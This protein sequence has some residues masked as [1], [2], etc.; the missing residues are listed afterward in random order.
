M[1]FVKYYFIKD[2][3]GLCLHHYGKDVTMEIRVAAEK[4]QWTVAVGSM[5]DVITVQIYAF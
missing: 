3:L 1:C 5:L 4:Q 2:F